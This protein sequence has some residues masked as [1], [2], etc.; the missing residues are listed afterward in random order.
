MAGHP[1]RPA[2]RRSLGGPLP[3]QQADRPRAH[4][5]AESISSPDHAIRRGHPVLA[6]VSRCYPGLRGRFLTCYSPVRHFPPGASSGLHVRLA[7]VKRAASVRPEPGSNSPSRSRTPLAGEPGERDDRR[8]ASRA[9]LR[10]RGNLTSPLPEGAGH[11]RNCVDWCSDDRDQSGEV[12]PKRPHW[13]LAFTVPLSRS[14]PE[15]RV[16]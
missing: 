13:L 2:T 11:V 5:E 1:L 3:H 14:C 9:T 15:A 6:P 4:P 8:A 7:C 12:W 10:S 16:G